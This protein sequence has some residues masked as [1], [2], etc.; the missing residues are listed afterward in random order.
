MGGIDIKLEILNQKQ[1]PAFYAD[2]FANRPAAGYVGRIFISTDT[3]VFYRDTGTT[4]VQVGGTGSGAITGS[5]TDG[6]ISFWTGAKSVSGSNNLFWDN[7]NGYFGIG[8]NTP[9]ANIDV[10]GSNNVLAQLNNTTTANSLIAFQN[11]GVGKWR[12]GNNYNANANDFYIYDTTNS[13]ARFNITNA[14]VFAITGLINLSSRLNINGASDN[15]SYALSVNGSLSFVGTSRQ[16][17][18][19]NNS[20]VRENGGASL[21]M[22]TVGASNV[23]LTTNNLDRI[24]VSPSGNSVFT[25]DAGTRAIDAISDG[26]LFAQNGG[27]HNIIFGDGNV[28]YYSIYTPAG[29]A[30]SSIRNFSTSTNILT[31]TSAGVLSTASRLNVNGATDNASYALNVNGDALISTT[32]NCQTI[33][34]SNYI[35]VVSG[36][37]T[38]A[39]FLVQNTGSGGSQYAMMAGNNN[40]DNTGFS[41]LKIGVG[42]ILR[43]NSSNEA[44]FV[45]SVTATSFIKQGGTGSQFLMA[46]GSVTT[47]GASISGTY[48][49]T[50]S[51]G[52]NTSAIANDPL[53]SVCYYSRVGNFVMVSGTLLV[54]PTTSGIITVA[55]INSLPIASTSTKLFSGVGSFITVGSTNESCDITVYPVSNV[56]NITFY[57]TGTGQV[58]IQYYYTYLTA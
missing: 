42:N 37:Q 16:I 43:F 28:R 15:A 9:G 49:P 31:W 6:Q 54:T 56:A 5:G 55:V 38:T 46:D 18:F 11:Q 33:T 30:S 27:A 22:G 40:V 39:R 44:S 1:T 13:L 34:T 12:I 8:I 20:F 58:R 57:A 32:L 17:I 24:V 2:V 45:N 52:G 36:D 19:G 26:V 41:I 21:E 7:T 25:P 23:K 14:G 35:S 3:L 10:H 29:A 50:Y 4:W 51:N 47:G 48:T 53:F